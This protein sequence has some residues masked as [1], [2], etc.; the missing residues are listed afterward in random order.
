MEAKRVFLGRLELLLFF[1]PG[2][3]LSLPRSVLVGVFLI[4]CCFFFL[5]QHC[6]F[7]M[8]F[9]PDRLTAFVEKSF[10][11]SS[12]QAGDR[13]HY[14]EECIDLLF[15]GNG[16]LESSLLCQQSVHGLEMVM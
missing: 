8:R 11:I 6:R 10:T 13:L 16:D 3:I 4:R 14:K 7:V 9:Q 15:E 2:V 5:P 12:F 1:M